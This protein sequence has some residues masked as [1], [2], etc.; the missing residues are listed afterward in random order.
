MEQVRGRPGTAARAPL[1][2]PGHTQSSNGRATHMKHCQPGKRPEPG[3]PGFFSG[4]S[5]RSARRPEGR[6]AFAVPILSVG[7]IQANG[8]HVLK[9]LSGQNGYLSE[10]SRGSLSSNRPSL[11]TAGSQW[12]SLLS[13]PAPTHEDRACR[14][15]SDPPPHHE[16]RHGTQLSGPGGTAGREQSVW[17]V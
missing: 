2:T 4:V 17:V 15:T 3:C 10:H 8:S 14:S 11:E 7:T 12:P 6:Q 13:Q 16:H 5:H 1:V 9:A